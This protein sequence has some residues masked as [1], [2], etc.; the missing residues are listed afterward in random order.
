MKT[1]L[2]VLV[3][4]LSLV[5]CSKRP[6]TLVDRYDPAAMEQAMQTARS[7]VSTFLAALEKGTADSYSVK[8]RIVDANGAEHFWISDVTFSGDT[9]SGVIGNE[10][11]IVKNVGL[12]QAWTVKKDEIS[13]WMYVVEGRIHG[14]YT[15]DPLL[16]SYP[17]D[18][19][20]A[21]RARL[22]R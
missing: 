13:D 21:L 22:V 18:Q 19:A 6:D 20:D 8:A 5:G 4:S 11:G 1:I 10:P 7:S 9:F 12:G 17:K 14:G 16:A 2:L 15:I 3:A